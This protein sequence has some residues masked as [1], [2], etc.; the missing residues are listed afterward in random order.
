MPSAFRRKM[1]GTL[2]TTDSTTTTATEAI[3]TSTTV[4][5]N[6]NESVSSSSTS[7]SYF[8]T[9]PS[10]AALQGVRPWQGGTYLTSF[11]L[12]DLDTI[13]GGG[14]PLGT[15]ILLEEDRWMYDL[16]RSLTKYWCAEV[17]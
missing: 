1:K 6:S 17:R 12:H 15:A 16:A 10:F 13:L 2:D 4:P 14:Q 11:G 8:V 7:P 3:S 5:V 9:G